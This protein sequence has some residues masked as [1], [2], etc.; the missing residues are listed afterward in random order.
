MKKI[1]L[2][3]YEINMR[4]QLWKYWEVVLYISIQNTFPISLELRSW[5]IL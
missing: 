5:F 4:V 2:E 1:F 3:T